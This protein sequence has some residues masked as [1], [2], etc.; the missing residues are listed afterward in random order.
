MLKFTLLRQNPKWDVGAFTVDDTFSLKLYSK[1]AG[2][3]I[4]CSELCFVLISLIF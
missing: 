3:Y 2:E 4:V 1:T